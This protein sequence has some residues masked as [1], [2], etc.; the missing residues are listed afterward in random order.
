MKLLILVRHSSPAAIPGL[1]PKQQP[2][3]EEGRLRCALLASRLIRYDPGLVIAVPGR[4]TAETGRILADILSTPFETM[5]N[6]QEHDR[7]N[8]NLS[9]EEDEARVA[10]YF[11]EPDHLV[12]GLQTANQ[13]YRSFCDAID[14]LAIKYPED[15]LVVVAFGAVMT[16]VVSRA[17]ELAPMPLWK[18]LDL[19][20]FVVLSWPDQKIIELVPRID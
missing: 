1:S 16:L 12:F 10:R 15:N 19:P 18:S 20:S 3:S 17:N 8:Q 13:S 5:E 4:K 11:G 2:L 9:K 7:E 6:L 14:E